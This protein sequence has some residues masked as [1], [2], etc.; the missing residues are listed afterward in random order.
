MIGFTSA[1]GLLFDFYQPKKNESD[2][3]VTIPSI[4]HLK[5]DTD[6]GRMVVNKIKTYYCDTRERFIMVNSRNFDLIW[7]KSTKSKVMFLS[8]K[9][10]TGSSE[11]FTRLQNCTL[12][13]RQLLFISIECPLN[14]KW[15]YW[16]NYWDTPIKVSHIKI[17]NSIS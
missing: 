12:Q 2:F 8:T 9:L 15:I 17:Y 4:F 5:P 10:I 16:K 13:H 3:D 7:F 11:T 14:R 1:E 6:L